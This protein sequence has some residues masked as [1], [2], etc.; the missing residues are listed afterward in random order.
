[1]SAADSTVG[2]RIYMARMGRKIS[3]QKLAEALSVTRA[4]ISQWERCGYQPSREATLLLT[5]KCLE[6]ELDW[7]RSGTGSVAPEIARI[8]PPAL[9][10]EI[11]K[12]LPR[13]RP[14]VTPWF[15][16]E[17]LSLPNDNFAR[18]KNIV[19][20]HDAPPKLGGV[21]AEMADG[22][23]SSV[24]L[25]PFTSV[26]EWW[27]IPP[28]IVHE[29]LRSNE[30]NLRGVR[31]DNDSMEPEIRH[32]DWIVFDITRR[33]PIDGRIFIIDTKLCCAIRRL[34]VIDDDSGIV[35]HA[36]TDK[37]TDESPLKIDPAIILGELKL[38]IRL[39]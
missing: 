18:L 20:P 4:A 13:P 22:V 1:M 34:R 21:I 9:P 32:G 37:P 14:R 15:T 36:V 27:R 38:H 35:V 33:T 23:G 29:Y 11:A 25:P 2:Q 3:Q 30:K 26:R 12:N 17:S 8:K 7:L 24:S 5:A 39:Y 31:I 28:G 16:A 6:V 10:K 19:M